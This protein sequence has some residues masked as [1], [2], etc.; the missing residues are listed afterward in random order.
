MVSALPSWLYSVLK[1]AHP[2]TR[3]V[4]LITLVVQFAATDKSAR[5]HMINGTYHQLQQSTSANVLAK[6]AFIWL[7][8]HYPDANT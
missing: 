4:S 6:P 2:D 8:N 1:S 5:Y 3:L 7:L